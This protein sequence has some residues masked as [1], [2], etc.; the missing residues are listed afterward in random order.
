MSLGTAKMPVNTAARDQSPA[1]RHITGN[2]KN[3]S[4]HGTANDKGASPCVEGR[5]GGGEG[6]WGDYLNTAT[7]TQT[8]HEPAN[9]RETG[10]A[11][12]V[13]PM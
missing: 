7:P 6:E 11:A 13:G 12:R 3:A 5:G 10:G 4:E 2:S 1:T 9:C 8:E